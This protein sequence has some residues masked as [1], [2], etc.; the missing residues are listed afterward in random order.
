PHRVRT[1]LLRLDDLLAARGL[2]ERTPHDRRDE[3]EDR[4]REHQLD[5]R[6]A[7]GCAPRGHRFTFGGGGS[8]NPLRWLR[9]LL[10]VPGG[11]LPPVVP[12]PPGPPGAPPGG[13]IDF[14]S[15][16]GSVRYCTT[17]IVCSPRPISSQITRTVTL[18][19]DSCRPIR[20]GSM[21]ALIMPP[22]KLVIIAIGS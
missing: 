20:I 1:L 8:V 2:R 6:E 13:S 11:V 16:D 9:G 4:H 22:R 15:C 17:S 19:T 3:R 14:S 10:L 5:H 7:G 21:N 18:R 12:V